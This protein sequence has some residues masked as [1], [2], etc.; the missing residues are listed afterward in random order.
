MRKLPFN[1]DE[2]TIASSN[3][4]QHIVNV[5]INYTSYTKCNCEI[6]NYK[7][8]ERR[9]RKTP[10]V[11]LSVATRVVIFKIVYFLLNVNCFC[12]HNNIIKVRTI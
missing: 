9:S 10:Y 5:I 6:H 7:A 2:T 3:K 8:T 4:F 1:L 12:W 11:D